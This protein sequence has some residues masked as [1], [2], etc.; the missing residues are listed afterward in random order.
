[1]R[2][3]EPSAEPGISEVEVR[4]KVR[5]PSSAVDSG[6]GTVKTLSA[7]VVRSFEHLLGHPGIQSLMVLD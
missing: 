5:I 4:F 6:M 7:A 2:L 1:V 3:P